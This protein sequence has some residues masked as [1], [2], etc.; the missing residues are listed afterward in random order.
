MKKKNVGL[1]AIALI[2]TT[3]GLSGCVEQTIKP[4]GTKLEVCAAINETTK[5]ALANY[6]YIKVASTKEV[7]QGVFNDMKSKGVKLD[8]S[9]E[10]QIQQRVTQVA[11]YV[12]S[13]T[14]PG[15]ELMNDCLQ[16]PDAQ[17]GFSADKTNAY[18]Q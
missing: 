1:V 8:A 7:V 14:Q 4:F 10:W 17:V 5:D 13:G 18:A 2:S 11:T 6:P 15:E 9:Q 3:V 16:L 12:R